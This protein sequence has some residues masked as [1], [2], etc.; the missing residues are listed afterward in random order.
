MNSPGIACLALLLLTSH[1][2]AVD[3]LLIEAIQNADHATL[4]S[5]LDR[6]DIDVNGSRGDGSTALSWAAYEDDEIAIDLLI[7]AGADVNVATDFHAVTPLA[8][9]C[10]NGN[11][12]AVAKLL[13]AVEARREIPL[14]RFIYALGIRQVGRSTARLLAHNYETLADLR[15]SMTAAADSDSS[16]Y[17]DLVN[18][19]GIGPAVAADIVGV[20]S[21]P[22][23][24]EVLDDL[25]GLLRIAPAPAPAASGSPLSGKTLVFTGTLETMTRGEAKARAETLG[26]KVVGS[27]SKKTDYAVVGADAGSKAKKAAELEVTILSE[28]DWLDL[29][30]RG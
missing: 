7:R 21:E 17:A 2:V 1:V 12:G 11:S 4:L 30:G 13:A 28:R 19:D 18:I 24:R 23:N 22:H 3:D 8:L 16:D 10:A 29:A 5:L 14:D 26:A 20:F 6:K 15:R 9:A 27:I 25:E